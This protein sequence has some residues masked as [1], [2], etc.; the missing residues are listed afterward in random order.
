M[1]SSCSFPTAH[2]SLGAYG[3]VSHIEAIQ[4]ALSHPPTDPLLGQLSARKL[5]LCPQNLGQI[6]EEMAMHFKDT[7]PEIE[8][9]LHAN[10]QL[11]AQPRWVDL[12][13]WLDAKDWFKQAGRISALLQAPVYTAHAGRRHKATLP[14]VLGYAKEAEQMMGIPVG[15]EGHY[16]TR[17]D[18]WLISSWPEYRCL[19]ESDVHYALDLSHLHIVACQTGCIE[20]GLVKE[21]LASPRCLEVHVSHNDGSGDQHWLL[22][23]ESPPW[24][25]AIL[26][27]G[28]SDAEMF[29]EGKQRVVSSCNILLKP[30]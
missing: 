18:R 27:R 9:R 6:T 30:R 2:V 8:F 5:Q 26:S 17:N 10:V 25:W 24:W 12:C 22:D 28:Y 13:D 11:E 23:R 14:Q 20:W 3:R 19:L 16:P 21:L 29:V 7:H 4:Q 1:N 15:I